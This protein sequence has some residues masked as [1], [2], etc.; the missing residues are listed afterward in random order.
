MLSVL[1]TAK[2]GERSYNDEVEVSWMIRPRF[3]RGQSI[4][5]HFF[6]TFSS[7]RQRNKNTIL[8]SMHRSQDKMADCVHSLGNNNGRLQKLETQRFENFPP[9]F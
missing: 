7:P 3:Y 1:N 4:F 9:P 5:M 8:Q 2:Q 6:P